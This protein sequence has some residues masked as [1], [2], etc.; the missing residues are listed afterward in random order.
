MKV[1]WLLCGAVER[2]GEVVAKR[3]YQYYDR[4]VEAL[5]MPASLLV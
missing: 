3:V 4:F 1:V 5:R 2:N